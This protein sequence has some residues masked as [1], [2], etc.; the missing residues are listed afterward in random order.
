MTEKIATEETLKQLQEMI[1]P[2]P[3]ATQ[4]RISRFLLYGDPGIGK[5]TLAA[6]IASMIGDRTIMVTTDPN[7]VAINKFPE[8]SKNVDQTNFDSYAQ[9]RLLLEARE[10]GVAPYCEYDTM[11]WD[12]VSTSV[13]KM[14]RL[15]VKVNDFKDRRDPNI[16]GRPDY[17]LAAQGLKDTLEMINESDLNVIY[18]A[19]VKDYENETA[20]RA[21]MP[22]A[23]YEALAQ[24]VQAIGFVHRKKED[25]PVQVLFQGTNRNQA[26]SQIPTL[27]QKLYVA[28]EVPELVRKWVRP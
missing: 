14:V 13:D 1:G 23:S 8:I 22:G 12:T 3:V 4:K 24:G 18:T 17:Y 2:A 9:V 27:D 16:A 10:M 19:H 6:M 28:N 11:I 26:K 15:S 20:L 7:W 25:D 21:N 5:S